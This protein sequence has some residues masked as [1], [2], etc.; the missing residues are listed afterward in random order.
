MDLINKMKNITI[1]DDESIDMIDDDFGNKLSNVIDDV[2]QILKSL[3]ELKLDHMNHK[4]KFQL[5]D[6][7]ELMDDRQFIGDQVVCRDLFNFKLNT[8]HNNIKDLGGILKYDVDLDYNYNSS[9]QTFF[10][11]FGNKY[12]RKEILVLVCLILDIAKEYNGFAFGGIVRD[13]IIPYIYFAKDRS[14]LDFKDVDIWFSKEEDAKNF[15]KS[16]SNKDTYLYIEEATKHGFCDIQKNEEYHKVFK[17]YQYMLILNG[18]NRFVID[19]IVSEF[20]PVNDV[21]MNLLLFKPKS[22]K[23]TEMNEDWFEVGKNSKNPYTFTVKNLI[24]S[25]GLK[26]SIIISDYYMILCNNR[27]STTLNYEICKSRIDS[28]IER[29]FTFQNYKN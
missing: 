8:I 1:S 10:K 27:I 21:A 2:G 11:C 13:Y 4:S 5:K 25:C 15:I 17:R 26:K 23:Y 22:D 19:I 16:L 9:K 18:S 28:F 20:L 29:G 12:T 6:G 14:K 7:G 3:N 24:L